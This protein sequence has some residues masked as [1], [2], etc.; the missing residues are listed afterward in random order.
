MGLLTVSMK[1]PSTEDNDQTKSACP[2]GE[3]LE[4]KCHGGKS[5]YAQGGSLDVRYN[6]SPHGR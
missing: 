1:Q 2:A 6:P 4:K 5:I 3:T